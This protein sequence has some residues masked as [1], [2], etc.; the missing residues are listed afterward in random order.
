[1]LISEFKRFLDQQSV[2]IN[3]IDANTWSFKY[4]GLNYIFISDPEDP[5]YFRIM[6]PNVSPYNNDLE[7][8]NKCL[9]CTTGVK[10]AKVLLIDNTIW[11]SCEQF[12]YSSNGFADLYKRSISTL[13]YL[14]K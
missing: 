6:L 8:L 12:I 1:M 14:Y 4:E 2:E 3:V 10:V 13:Q 9:E 7:F 5:Y 11:L